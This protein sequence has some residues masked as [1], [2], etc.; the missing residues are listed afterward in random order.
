MQA[1]GTRCRSLGLDAWPRRHVPAVQDGA[2]FIG[3]LLKIAQLTA[4]RGDLRPQLASAAVHPGNRS[5]IRMIATVEPT[6]SRSSPAFCRSKCHPSSR[7]TPYRRVASPAA[8]PRVRDRP[9][10]LRSCDRAH[11]ERRRRGRALRACRGTRGSVLRELNIQRIHG[12]HQ[13]RS[14]RSRTR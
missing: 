9:Y 7:Q 12:S 2:G 1:R 6:F 8:R 14:R 3:T 4:R 10:A 13:A 5:M 11:W